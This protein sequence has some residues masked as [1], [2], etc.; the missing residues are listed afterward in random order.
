MCF[1]FFS[2]EKK[3]AKEWGEKMKAIATT[4]CSIFFIVS[5]YADFDIEEKQIQI[6]IKRRMNA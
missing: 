5:A 1:F 2:A 4:L 6:A 3:E